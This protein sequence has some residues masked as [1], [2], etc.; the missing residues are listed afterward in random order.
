MKNESNTLVRISKEIF[1]EIGK[2]I[3]IEY[4]IVFGS[5]VKGTLGAESDIDFAVKL[6]KLPKRSGTLLKTIVKIKNL[7]EGKLKREVDIVILNRS[8]LGLWYE[9]FSTGRPVYVLSEEDFFR[10]KVRVIKQYLDFKYYIDRHFKEKVERIV[11]G[12]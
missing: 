6:K 2:E 8:S 12:E 4:A 7:L 10:D 9:V 11:H 1:E 3:G 5:A